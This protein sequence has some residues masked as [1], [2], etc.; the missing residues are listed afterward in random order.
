MV[1]LVLHGKTS[2]IA[3]AE[4]ARGKFDGSMV[5]KI[6]SAENERDCVGRFWP[7]ST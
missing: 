1:L 3:I 4:T 7:E 5:Q 6:Q 2:Q